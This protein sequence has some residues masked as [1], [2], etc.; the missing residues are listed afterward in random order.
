M[1]NTEF[2]SLTI[3]KQKEQQKDKSS[4]RRKGVDVHKRKAGKMEILLHE[5]GKEYHVK[6]DL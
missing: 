1:L 4:F 6:F 2:Q 5:A 3:I